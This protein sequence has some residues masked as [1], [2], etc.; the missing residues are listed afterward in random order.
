MD[1][2]KVY[3]IQIN[4]IKESTD[5]VQNLNKVLNELDTKIKTIEKNSVNISNVASSGGSKKTSSTASMS[6][7]EKLAKQIE[8][9]DSRRVVYSKEL[10][11]NYLAAKEVLDETVKD[12]KAIAAQ[13]RI[14]ANTYSNTM[15]GMKDKLR[16]IQTLRNVTDMATDEFKELTAEANELVQKLKQI[17]E[18]TGS[19]GRNVG[20]YKGV[21]EGLDKIS[22]SINGVVQEF[23]S[24]RQAQKA[25]T[26]Q[27]GVLETNG[28]KDTK[29]YRDLERE[30][31]KVSKAQL[32]LNSAM[33]DAKASSRAMDDLLDTMESFTSLAGLGQSFSSLFGLDDS[34]MQ[35]QLVKIQALSNALT[36]LEKLRQQMNTGEG[37]GGLFSKGSKAIDQFVAKLGGAEVR[38]GKIIGSSKKASIALNGLS[39][40]LK[41]ITT[42]GLAIAFPFILSFLD[43]FQKK[44]KEMVF[45]SLS[46]ADAAD[47]LGKKAELLAKAA[48]DIEKT[49]FKE[50]LQGTITQEQYMID[51]TQ[52][53]SDVINTLISDMNNIRKIDLTDLTAGFQNGFLSDVKIGFSSDGYNPNSEDIEERA[54]AQVAAMQNALKQ[55]EELGKKMIELDEKA[56]HSF[57]PLLTK[58]TNGANDAARD[59][60]QTGQIITRKML[61]DLKTITEAFVN[62]NEKAKSEIAQFGHVTKET[63]KELD[64]YRSAIIALRESLDQPT[65]GSLFD[66]IDKF[67]KSGQYYV[68]QIGIIKQALDDL[69][70]SMTDV[71]IDADKLLQ[72]RI[73]GMAESEEK[74]RKQ[75][76]LNRKK[77]LASVG[78]NQEY[79]DAI[80]KKYDREL[81]ESLKAY[82]KSKKQEADQ[83]KKEDREIQ[84]EID[85]YKLQ[86]M[87]EGLAK[88]I[89]ALT[90]ERDQKL[91]EIRDSGIRVAERSGLVT[92]VYDKKILKL[93]KDWAVEME[94]I[95]EDMYSKILDIQKDAESKLQ[96][97]SLTD[98][99]LGTTAKKDNA[100]KGSL[101]SERPDDLG[102]RKAYYQD[103]LDIEV[104]AA[105]KEEEIL[106]D[107]LAKEYKYA[108]EEE[109]L[110][111]KRV[112]D[113][114][115]VNLVMQE[116]AN[117][118]NPTSEQYAEMEK[119]LQ[120][121]LSEMNGELVDAYNEGKLDFDKFVKLIQQEQVA[122]NAA[123]YALEKEYNTNSNKILQDGLD[124]KTQAYSTYYTNLLNNV[125]TMQDNISKQMQK[126][127]VKDDTWGVVKISRSKEQYKQ[128]I[129]EYSKVSAEIKRIQTDLKKDLEKGNIKGEEFFMKNAELEAMKQSAE[130]A[131]RDVLERQ[132]QLGAEFMQ[133]IQQYIQAGMQAFTQVLQA[134][135]DYQDNVFDD[136]QEEIDKMND[137]LDKA[138]DKQ[139]QIVEEHKSNIDSLED[140]LANSRGSR[141]QHLIDQI[142]AEIDAE[143]AA[144]K[145]KKKIEKEQEK[146]QKKQDELDKKRK[147]AQYKRDMMQAIVNGAMA[148]TM[149]AVNAWPV[150]AIPMM[151]LAA[152]ATAAQIAIMASNKPY[153]KGGQL[154][155]GVAQGNRHRDGG[156]K[157]LGGRA[158]IEGGEFITNR[159]TTEKN[160]QLL[161]FINEKHKKLDLDDFIDFYSSGKVRKNIS[162]SS[163]KRTFAD[164]GVIPT[165]R[166]DYNIDDKLLTAFESYNDRPVV[167]SV[168]DINSRQQEVRNVRVLA[169]LD[170]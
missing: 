59:F 165:M 40:V 142:N 46:A 63:Q 113:E 140:Q 87:R 167:V 24:L 57:I 162:S 134:I 97:N 161:D 89:K 124:K 109:K 15:Q 55:F 80:N 19:F 38:M 54:K 101:N 135:W 143:R 16:D 157:V 128:A 33:K 153:A 150:P 45:G 67:S 106:R 93:K 36:H 2:K 120:S 61:Y 90:N 10:Y 8:Q 164:G 49:K 68:Q 99:Q 53:L 130:D 129:E 26:N 158:E 149:A 91:A 21:F 96:D 114:K 6:E 60:E 126:T 20:N 69:A 132:K 137:K 107:K 160:V 170:E 41:G 166:N 5:A 151:A 103:L 51:K 11:Q 32:R 121:S 100:W 136:E 44:L 155:G 148:V 72:L 82:R 102:A 163:P 66:N 138:L 73:D 169:G 71:N 39:T 119:K 34:D 56:E 50:Y 118:P 133:S 62:T 17:E 65:I 47:V 88:E 14:Q 156:I 75:N 18:A 111:T 141:R 84:N 145:E 85:D 3:Q 94:K 74:I 117:T 110:R 58:M 108:Q 154:D 77:E 139:Q 64:F 37:I 29:M 98:L 147:K 123:M 27:M 125:K 152:A 23:N 1:G 116:I 79:V 42:G 83:K 76:D 81:K 115:T 7:E 104:D 131:T 28:K 12:Q 52:A 4:G 25:I 168:V 13:E 92:A 35:K 48:K 95:Y 9:I 30:L 112:A 78:F 122:H 127:P 159:I 105:Q 31:E 86:L 43:S 70:S 22:V 146:Q 144:A